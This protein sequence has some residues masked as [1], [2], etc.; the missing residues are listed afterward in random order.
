MSAPQWMVTYSD[1]VTQLLALFVILFAISTVDVQRFEAIMSAFRG[2]IGILD[3]G[4]SFESQSSVG[5]PPIAIAPN[6]TSASSVQIQQVYRELARVVEAEG[7]GEGVKLVPEERGIVVRF[8]DRVL[9][10]LGKDELRPESMRALDVVA[11]VLKQIPNDV[12]VEGHTDNL[13]I[14]NERFASN[15]ELSVARATRVVRYLIER[16]GLTPARL[17][18]AGY[19]EFHP[20]VPNTSEANRQKN[21]RVDVVILR[22]GLKEEPA[23]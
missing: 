15:W 6:P 14:H 13:P 22:T 9:F 2:A 16:H 12:R 20:L 8:A 19:G 4:R 18:A 7:L 5:S 11:G 21:R 3:T 17:S 10:D 23:R 1:M